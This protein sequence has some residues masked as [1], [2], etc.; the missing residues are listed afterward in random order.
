MRPFLAL[1][2]V[3]LALSSISVFATG[4]EPSPAARDQLLFKNGDRLSGNL[5]RQD[6]SVIVFNSTALGEITVPQDQARIVSRRDPDGV[7]I[8]ALVGIAPIPAR[9]GPTTIAGAAKRADPLPAKSEV[10]PPA[11]TPPPQ[12]DTTAAQIAESL[13]TAVEEEDWDGKVEF[14]LRQ[15]Q[16]RS[17]IFAV[18]IRASAERTIRDHEL[19]A[20]ARALYGE[21]DGEVNNDRYDASFQWRRELGERTFAQSL[22]S[23][24]QDDLKDINRN[25]EQNF[26]AGYRFFDNT[27]HVVSI[28]A[29]LT[30]QYREASLAQSGFFT[31]VEIFQDYTYRINK[32][33]TVRQNAQVQYS[34][35]GGTRFISVSN[36][37]SSAVQEADNYKVRF[38]T[39][40]QGKLT[41]QLSMNLRFEFE[42]DNAVRFSSDRIDQRI[43]TS[44]GYAF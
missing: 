41:R 17:D 11:S 29:G 27:S 8:E 39:V 3:F 42:Y 37:P 1:T 36:Q 43:I 38:N 16:G 18:D 31:L 12:P 13:D 35:E 10:D 14:G 40:L 33:I 7:P 6:D 2:L 25:W 24:F 34:P 15:Q 19:R 44:L 21:Q 9:A 22:T 32:R 20:N 30:G 23:Y 26:G 5:V 28:G 4:T